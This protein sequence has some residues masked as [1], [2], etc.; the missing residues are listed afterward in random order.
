LRGNLVRHEQVQNCGRKSDKHNVQP[1]RG[2]GDLLVRE[3]LITSQQLNEALKAATEKKEPLAMALVRLKVVDE[4]VLVQFFSKQYRLPIMDLSNFIPDPTVMKLFPAQIL[5]KYSFVPVGKRGDTM[6]I[7]V[8]DPTNVQ[9]LD[10]IR[11][12][13][14]MRVEQVLALPSVIRSIAAGGGETLGDDMGDT[15]DLAALAEG[16][17]LSDDVKQDPELGMT[18]DDAPIVKFAQQILADAVRRKASDIHIE[19]YE[20]DMRIRFRID[21]DLVELHKP[22]NAVKAALTA[23]LK[24][25][26]KMRLDEKRLPQDGRVRLKLSEDRTV[27]FRVNTLPTVF[28]EKV[29]LRILDKS[30]AVV[31]IDQ[32]GFEPDDLVKVVKG[33]KQPW[34][35]CLVTGATGS[36][37]TTTLYSAL[38]MLNTPDVNISTIEDPVEY[39]FPGINQSQTKDQ[40]GLTFAE[41]LRALLRQDPD[42]ILLGEIRDQETAE[43]AFK[44]ALTGHL[45]LSTLHTNDA[46][47]TIMRLKDMGMDVFT[48]NSAL[49]LIV[50]QRLVRRVCKKC[51]APDP[52][53]TPEELTKLGFPPTMIGKFTPM[54]G[55]GCNECRNTGYKGRAALHEVLYMTEKMKEIVGSGASSE[56]IR[57]AAV[58]DGMKTMRVNM[59]RKIVAGVCSIEELST[60]GG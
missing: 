1:A 40:I 15:A 23:R 54:K 14:R 8:A 12:Q 42:I 7:A 5:S 56:E 32:I 45:V 18:A 29:V 36:G 13:V 21:G 6:V 22:P 44:A 51:K 59:M 24:V 16:L 4:Q 25:M 57:K 17:A 19:P 10:D 60:L 53:A 41:C 58:A 38:N 52:G 50:A 49:H 2:L 30:N 20:K 3:K 55:T 26:A 9:M 35:I 47:S 46:P 28:G 31:G 39:N 43:I 27:D 37:K 34:G 48:I 33:I 11:F